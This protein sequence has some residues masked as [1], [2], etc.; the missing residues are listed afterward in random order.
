MHVDPD[1]YKKARIQNTDFCLWTVFPIHT[2]VHYCTVILKVDIASG[3]FAWEKISKTI[4]QKTLFYILSG[5]F[6]RSLCV[7]NL[8]MV[9][10]RYEI[11]SSNSSN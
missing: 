3:I 11:F 6:L 10:Q 2:V 5:F 7:Q 1:L 9:L 4:L 8:K